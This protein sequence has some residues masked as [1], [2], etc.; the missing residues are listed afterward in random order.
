MFAISTMYP[1]KQ[2]TTFG[3]S[4]EAAGLQDMDAL[5]VEKIA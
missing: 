2:L 5:V 4:I 3:I 1:R